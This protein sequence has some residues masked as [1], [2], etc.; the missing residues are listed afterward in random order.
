MKQKDTPQ[1]RKGRPLPKILAAPSSSL[2]HRR[3]ISSLAGRLLGHLLLGL[4]FHQGRVARHLPSLDSVAGEDLLEGGDYHVQPALHPSLGVEGLE[5][6]RVQPA[7]HPRL[8]VKGLEGCRVQPALH[9]SLGVEGLESCR[10]QPALHP[11]L[12]VEG[13]EGCR[14]QPALH[15]SLGGVDPFLTERYICM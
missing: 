11:S 10:E 5:S 12:G 15:P 13:L 8:G 1:D 7:L 14:V 2:Q 3:Q 6:C 4:L 9:P